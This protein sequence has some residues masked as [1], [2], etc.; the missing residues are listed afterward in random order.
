MSKN[1]W[2]VA[3]TGNHQGL[4]VEENT[5]KNI[6][7]SYEKDNAN[8]LAA[9][10]ELLEALQNCVIDAIQNLTK[11]ERRERIKQAEQAINNATKQEV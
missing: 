11:T 8:L 4:I 3:S 6:A 7:V 2:Y 1:N 9:A 5:G 10:P